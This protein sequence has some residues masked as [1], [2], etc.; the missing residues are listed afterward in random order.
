MAGLQ[1]LIH[2]SKIQNT[3]RN[4][5]FLT[6]LVAKGKSNFFTQGKI[7][8]I[9]LFSIVNVHPCRSGDMFASRCCPSRCPRCSGTQGTS[10][11]SQVSNP[12][13][14]EFRSIGILKFQI[15]CGFAFLSNCI[16][17][18]KLWNRL[19]SNVQ[20]FVF[21]SLKG[22]QKTISSFTS[23]LPAFLFC[24]RRESW[25]NNEYSGK[26]SIIYFS[27]GVQGSLSAVDGSRDVA[28]VFH[29][30]LYVPAV[31]ET[32]AIAFDISRHSKAPGDPERFFPAWDLDSGH[33]SR[34]NRSH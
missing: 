12:R 8:P 10:T 22:M 3:P 21:W 20:I 19:I 14:S 11:K 25:S 7:W 1:S 24:E 6:H 18:Y 2:N 27:P 9:S 28:G 31:C 33:V 5:L 16:S 34:I 26:L 30:E 4:M 17:T 15:H 29:V 23:S 32:S 13:N